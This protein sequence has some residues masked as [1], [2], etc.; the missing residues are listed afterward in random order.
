MR[1]IA[2]KNFTRPSAL[3]SRP[4]APAR[5]TTQNSDSKPAEFGLE[6]RPLKLTTGNESPA[7][8]VAE[9]CLFLLI[10]LLAVATTIYCFDQL[11]RL[12]PGDS[13]SN[14]I[15]VLLR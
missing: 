6:S 8:S 10:W 11:F 15:R 2:T 3:R 1:T 14:T 12:I 9:A 13:L 7:R 4:G 5:S